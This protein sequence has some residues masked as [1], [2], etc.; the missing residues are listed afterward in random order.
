MG[1]VKDAWGGETVGQ[2]PRLMLPLKRGD[3]RVFSY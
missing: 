2:R 3:T 1:P